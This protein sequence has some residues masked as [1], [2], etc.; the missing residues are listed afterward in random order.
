MCVYIYTHIYIYICNHNPNQDAK[1][2]H[3]LRT[4]CS[5]SVDIPLQV[6]STLI[7]IMLV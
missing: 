7:S 5:F 4:T 1:H 2:F 6:T 3:Q